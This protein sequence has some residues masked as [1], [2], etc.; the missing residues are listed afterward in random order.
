MAKKGTPLMMKP[1]LTMSIY[2]RAVTAVGDPANRQRRR[3]TENGDCLQAI[4]P[5]GSQDICPSDRNSV[6][7]LK[8]ATYHAPLA[9]SATAP[10][11]D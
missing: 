4:N 8:Y 6:K 2:R 9:G 7:T 10:R 11:S 3:K 1:L 5:P